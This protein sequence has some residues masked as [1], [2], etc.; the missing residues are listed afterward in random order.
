[1]ENN[2]NENIEKITQ[3]IMQAKNEDVQDELQLFNSYM[4]KKN[5]VRAAKYD[6]LMDDVLLEMQVRLETGASA[7]ENLE[8]LKYLQV[9]QEASEKSINIA[10]GNSNVPQIKITQNNVNV[11][12]SELPK[13][14][15]DRVIDFVN[16]IL[17]NSNTEE[18]RIIIDEENESDE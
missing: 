8:L 11:G 13:E 4:L 15:R 6:T 17:N 7:F 1:M 14:S 18:N 16:K 10:N 9:L 2:N 5:A 12:Q 3:S